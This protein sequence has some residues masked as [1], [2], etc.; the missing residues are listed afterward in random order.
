[1]HANKFWWRFEYLLRSWNFSELFWSFEA[2]PM[3]ICV[4]QLCF[5]ST[6]FSSLSVMLDAEC[7][8]FRWALK[9]LVRIFFVINQKSFT[10]LGTLSNRYVELGVY[11]Y[12]GVAVDYTRNFHSFLSFLHFLGK[13][14]EL[15]W[16]R[17]G[18]QRLVIGQIL[19][20]HANFRPVLDFV[21]YFFSDWVIP[22]FSGKVEWR[23]TFWWNF[24]RKVT[25]I[26]TKN[27]KDRYN[28]YVTQR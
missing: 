1:M 13:N 7:F 18:G 22:Y 4:H 24:S 6:P 2:A 9:L 17:D 20:E 3:F 11:I 14:M 10:F 28:F 27:Q 21:I 12:S 8:G 23:C 19:R 5:S 16:L 15:S 26:S 25:F